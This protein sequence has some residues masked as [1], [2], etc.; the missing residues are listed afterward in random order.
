[1]LV[2]CRTLAIEI[3]SKFNLWYTYYIADN[4]FHFQLTLLLIDSTTNVSLFCKIYYYFFIKKKKEINVWLEDISNIFVKHQ[5][6]YFQKLKIKLRFNW[7]DF[8]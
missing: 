6:L 5:D 4:T 8:R 1:M 2:L 3:Q 7:D